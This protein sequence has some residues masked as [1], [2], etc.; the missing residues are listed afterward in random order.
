MVKAG[1]TMAKG[2][3]VTCSLLKKTI[4]MVGT[5][6]R[7][8]M[9]DGTMTNLLRLIIVKVSITKE[10]KLMMVNVITREIGLT[11]KMTKMVTINGKLSI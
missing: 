11:G 9:I 5:K 2:N 3:A 6:I 10:I 8:N 7:K 4:M 1:N